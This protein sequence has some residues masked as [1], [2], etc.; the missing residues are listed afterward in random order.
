[1]KLEEGKFYR[2]RD[3]RR[4]GPIKKM[5][6]RMPGGKIKWESNDVLIPNI[7]SNWADDGICFPKAPQQKW[8][9]CDLIEECE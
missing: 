2:T 1:M 6:G 4:V 5:K 7:L 9:N 8:K 3:G